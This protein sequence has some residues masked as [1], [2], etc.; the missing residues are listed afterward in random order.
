[1]PAISNAAF[2]ASTVGPAL[3]SSAIDGASTSKL[4]KRR[5]RTAAA[6]R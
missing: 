1:M 6:F 2:D 5:E 4:P 3:C